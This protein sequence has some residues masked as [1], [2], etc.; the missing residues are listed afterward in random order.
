[1]PSYIPVMLCERLTN[2]SRLAAGSML[3][4]AFLIVHTETDGATAA[5]TINVFRLTA[6]G[7]RVVDSS[8]ATASAV[9][10][11]Q[12]ISPSELGYSR[13]DAFSFD[14]LFGDA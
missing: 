11:A 6:E 5:S 2:I 12:L 7:D 8:D 1:M 13:G 4:S 3:Q 10:A 14:V 9:L